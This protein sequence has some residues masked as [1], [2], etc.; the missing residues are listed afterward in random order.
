MA[1]GI[2]GCGCRCREGWRIVDAV[3][4]SATADA[5]VEAMLIIESELDSHS[6]EL[7]TARVNADIALLHG[8]AGGGG[9]VEKS[10]ALQ[11]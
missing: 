1:E 8:F 5:W 10:S 6:E 4:R 11:S 9:F 3:R 2:I 7:R